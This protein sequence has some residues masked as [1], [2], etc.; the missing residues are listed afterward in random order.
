MTAPFCVADAVHSCASLRARA[1]FPIAFAG[2]P[3]RHRKRAERGERRDSARHQHASPERLPAIARSRSRRALLRRYA[4]PA[5]AGFGALHASRHDIRT[6][7]IAVC[8]GTA[9]SLGTTEIGSGRSDQWA[10][11]LSPP[12]LAPWLPRVGFS[13]PTL[14][15]LSIALVSI[16][17][18]C[19]AS[20]ALSPLA[21]TTL[22]SPAALAMAAAMPVPVRY[23]L[24]LD[25]RVVFPFSTSLAIGPWYL[26][27]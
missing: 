14:H 1:P 2:S 11:A 24:T 23:D 20:C 10:R 7:A 12:Q 22:F 8:T 26:G 27:A 9:S 6:V 21:R 16:V 5:Q 4:D 3:P 18:S 17:S 15:S 19:S 25:D 13:L